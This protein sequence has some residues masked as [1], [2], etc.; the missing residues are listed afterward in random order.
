[1]EPTEAATG[2]AEDK[3]GRRAMKTVWRDLPIIS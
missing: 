3:A 1:M 2:A